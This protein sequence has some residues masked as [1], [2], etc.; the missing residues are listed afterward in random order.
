M[1]IL[2]ILQGKYNGETVTN[3]TSK[4]I[5]PID[6]N[7]ESELGDIGRFVDEDGNMCWG[8]GNEEDGYWKILEAYEMTEPTVELHEDKYP[9][10]FLL[11]E[12][13]FSE[14]VAEANKRFL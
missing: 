9:V 1:D 14:I 13:Q 7:N 5:V 4:R 6:L 11:D 12:G 8:L 2:L 3:C 10:S